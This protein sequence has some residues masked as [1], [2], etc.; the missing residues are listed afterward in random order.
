MVGRQ[1][2]SASEVNDLAG[3]IAR[4]FELACTKVLEYKEFLDRTP[5]PVLTSPPYSM[6]GGDIGII[7]SA[8]AGLATAVNDYYANHRTFVEQLLG[9]G[10]HN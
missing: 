2:S 10:P 8:Y 6:D 5:D 9:P 4:E 1:V 7:K 3:N